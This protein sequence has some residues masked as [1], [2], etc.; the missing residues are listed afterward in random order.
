MISLPQHQ[1][2]HTDSAVLQD[3]LSLLWPSLLLSSHS[4][5]GKCISRDP[6]NPVWNHNA[7]TRPTISGM[8]CAVVHYNNISFAREIMNQS[9]SASLNILSFHKP[10]LCYHSIVL[11]LIIW[12]SKWNPKHPSICLSVHMS[13]CPSVR[14]CLSIHLATGLSVCLPYICLCLSICLSKCIYPPNKLWLFPLYIS[15]MPFS[16]LSGWFASG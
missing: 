12:T 4:Q 5:T 7:D 11:C 10:N 15:Q 16:C 6:F 8:W 1:H 14:V 2:T 9:L 13:V 3:V